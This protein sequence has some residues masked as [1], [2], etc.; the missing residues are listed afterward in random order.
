MEVKE[1][2]KKKCGDDGGY[3]SAIRETLSNSF[4]AHCRAF[5]T[6]I[7]KATAIATTAAKAVI[8]SLEGFSTLTRREL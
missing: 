5:T 3:K 1:T 8:S 6:P 2:R 7:A 4:E